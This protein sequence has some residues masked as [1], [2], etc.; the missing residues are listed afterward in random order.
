MSDHTKLDSEI[1][2]FIDECRE[3]EHADSYL[4]AVLH[5][6]QGKY[7]YLSDEHMHEVAQRLQVPSSTVSGVATFYHFFR[8]QP[9][10]KYHISLCLGTACFV[11]GAD[12][13]LE[14]F[15]SELG[16]ELGETTPDKLFS[17]ECSR[18][19]GVCALAPVVTINDQVYSKVSPTQ[20]AELINKA[21]F[22]EAA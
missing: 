8:L 1:I 5:K 6:I 14:A 7:G 13:I 3:K 9:K 12:K 22:E 20:V 16:I 18:C 15:R 4:I 2:K 17:L 19:L 21:R 10:G 11:K